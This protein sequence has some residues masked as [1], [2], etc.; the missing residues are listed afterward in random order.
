M[1]GLNVLAMAASAKPSA[2]P[3][4]MAED[5]DDLKGEDPEISYLTALPVPS[6]SECA[7]L[8]S[9]WRKVRQCRRRKHLGFSSVN[10]QGPPFPLATRGNAL[11]AALDIRP[12]IADVKPE[13]TSHTL[14]SVR[15]TV[16]NFPSD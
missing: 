7:E 9:L 3:Q 12:V 16:C 13:E 10:V 1:D 2:L 14:P 6:R 8:L 15:G 5:Q 4:P 11:L